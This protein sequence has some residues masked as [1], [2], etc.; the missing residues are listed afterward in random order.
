MHN[1]I[2]QAALSLGFDACGIAK[3]EAL[4]EDARFLQQ[5]LAE[6]KHGEMH[7]LARNFEKRTDPRLLVPGCK[8]VVVTLL[9]Y[10]PEGK[11]PDSAPRLAKYAYSEVDYHT[12]IKT[13][14]KELK[15]KITFEYG[16]NCVSDSHQYSFVDSAPVLERRWAERTG[17]GWIGKNTQ[18]INPDLGSFCFIAI[19]MLNVEMAEYDSPMPNR[20]GTCTACI[21]ACP[22][23]ALCN[24]SM[25][26]RRCLSYLTIELKGEIPFEFR[27]DFPDIILGCDICGDV[28]P[29]NKKKA[30]SHSHPEL[31]AIPQVEKWTREDWLN[32]D[33][34][35]F[36][37]MFRQSAVKRAGFAKLKQNLHF[38]KENL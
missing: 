9:N 1:F 5:W 31:S 27:S 21:K 12:V 37:R 26:A 14:L 7:Y 17:L 15:D 8:S 30:R 11:Q 22:T 23:S 10:Y 34:E 38:G 28:C 3:A 35:E 32:M 6:G 4:E 24:A 13:K 16:D 2:K 20:C 25:D 33:E 19:L 18:L 36:K 29:W